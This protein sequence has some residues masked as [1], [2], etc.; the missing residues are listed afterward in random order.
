MEG[1]VPASESQLLRS[2]T[3]EVSLTQNTKRVGL[4]R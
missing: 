4:G 1:L 2:L 3:T